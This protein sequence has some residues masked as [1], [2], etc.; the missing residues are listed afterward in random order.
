MKY[1]TKEWYKDSLI[2]DMCFQLRKTERAAL[3][4]EAFFERLYAV[5]ERAYLKFSKRAAKTYNK[6]FDKDEAKAEFASNYNE[7][8]EF[9]KETLPDDILCDIKDIRVLALGS[10]THD[11]A[12]R[13]TRFCGKKNRLC[14]SIERSY[15]NESEAADEALG[16]KASVFTS[17]NGSTITSLSFSNDAAVLISFSNPAEETDASFSLINA[18]LTDGD[19]NISGMTVIRHELLLSADAGFEF[20]LLLMA[21]DSSLHTVSYTASDISVP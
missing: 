4:S 16:K 15:D 10:V 17:L 19:D 7:N 1:F 2:A 9:V 13:I 8:L 5:E 20:S 6:P 3:F 14:E 21:K 11:L 12:M 18:S